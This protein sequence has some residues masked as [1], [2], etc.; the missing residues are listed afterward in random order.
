MSR[1]AL[2]GFIEGKEVRMVSEEDGC[3]EK[4]RGSCVR[5]AD[6]CERERQLLA[7]VA[8]TS[9]MQQTPI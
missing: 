6:D 1:A 9:Y 4:V 8:I 5:L 3:S 2:M 7:A